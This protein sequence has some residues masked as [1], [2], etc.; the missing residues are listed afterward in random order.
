[1]KYKIGDK[2]YVMCKGRIRAAFIKKIFDPCGEWQSF[3]VD[4]S[5]EEYTISSGC[6][7][8]ITNR[9]WLES[10]SDEE[11]SKFNKDSFC[12][13]CLYNTEICNKDGTKYCDFVKVYTSW[14]Q[15]EHKE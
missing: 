1:M 3:I 15:A 14:L 12:K 10:L 7:Q 9:Q 4:I 11:L 13:I 8:K 5:G 2:V 6:I